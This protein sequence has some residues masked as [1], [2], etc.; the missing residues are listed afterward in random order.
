MS[1]NKPLW[2][3]ML[4]AFEDAS[5]TFYDDYGEETFIR[6]DGEEMAAILRVIADEVVP[7]EY[8]PPPDEI[9]DDSLIDHIIYTAVKQRQQIRQRLL[10]EAE[11]AETNLSKT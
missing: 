11:Q 6:P 7:E 2:Q 4:A 3:K 8:L 9:A 5:V 10:T 1:N